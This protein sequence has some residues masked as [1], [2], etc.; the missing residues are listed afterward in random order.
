[1][2]MDKEKKWNEIRKQKAIERTKVNFMFIERLQISTL[3]I[4]TYMIYFSKINFTIKLTFGKLFP[5]LGHRC[6]LDY[7]HEVSQSCHYMSAGT[8]NFRQLELT[9]LYSHVIWTKINT[10]IP[11]SDVNFLVKNTRG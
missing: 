10:C 2:G 5:A 3:L 4:Q 7:A 6:K 9:P 11:N 8:Q 1:M